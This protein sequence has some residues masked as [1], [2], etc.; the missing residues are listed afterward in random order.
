MKKNKMMRLA[1]GL[2]VAVLITTS[3]I[4]GTF[5]KYTTADTA[6]DSARV[7]K[8][9]VTVT[10][11]DTMFA[12]AYGDE[13]VSSETGVKV[14]AP[15]TDG[16]LAKFDVEGK[17]EVAVEVLYDA[18]LTL[19]NWEVDGAY[20]CPLI[21]TVN[22]TKFDGATY[23]SSTDFEEA[24]EAKIEAAAKEYAPNVDLKD[25]DN[26]LAVSWEWPFEVGADA[27]EKAANNANDTKLGRAA[28][29]ATI[30]DEEITVK[31]NVDCIINQLEVY[32]TTP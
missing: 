8:W 17:T 3:T 11:T 27:D 12:E 2:L 32:P 7:A 16:N 21:I 24:V 23:G 28:E 18:D 10:A 5:A 22:G 25:V 30:A 19:K 15:G 13:V 29:A 26:D 14:V 9:G 4:S 31:L 20:Y 1:S 6:T